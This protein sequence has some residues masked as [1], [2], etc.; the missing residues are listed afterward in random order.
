LLWW[1]AWTREY[2]TA[3]N[4]RFDVSLSARFDSGDEF[5][6]ESPMGE[7]FASI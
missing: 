2:F 6:K 4:I 1:D 3:R 5:A 7:V